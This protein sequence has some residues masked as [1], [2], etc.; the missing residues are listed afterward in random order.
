MVIDHIIPLSA[1]G[2]TDIG[3]LTLSCYRCNE[4]KGGRMNAVDPDSGETVPLF[5]PCLQEWH[6][7]FAWGEDGS[8]VIGITATGRATVEMLHLKDD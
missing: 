6:K 5:N 2:T 1:G 8:L 3:N 4:V 7:H